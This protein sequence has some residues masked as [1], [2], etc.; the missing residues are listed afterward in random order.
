M[1]LSDISKSLSIDGKDILNSE[2]I[3]INEHTRLYFY[4]TEANGGF[5]FVCPTVIGY[6]AGKNNAFYPEADIEI[7]ISGWAAFDGVRHLYFGSD[8][9]DNE[10]Y[11]NYPDIELLA[12]VLSELRK[13]E[14]LYCMDHA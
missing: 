9:S 6:E 10:G 13:L 7:V 1:I 8:Q 2:F 11:F 5:Y 3:E 14:K 12:H 4:V